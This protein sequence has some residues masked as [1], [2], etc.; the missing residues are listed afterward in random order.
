MSRDDFKPAPPDS[1]PQHALVRRLWEGQLRG[2]VPADI[3]RLM[4]EAATELE[5]NLPATDGLREFNAAQACQG[6]PMTPPTLE[7]ALAKLRRIGNGAKCHI[8][9]KLPTPKEATALLAKIEVA[10]KLVEFLVNLR[11]ASRGIAGYHLNGN[12]AEWDEFEE[13]N[14]LATYR[15]PTPAQPLDVSRLPM[16]DPHPIE[17]VKAGC[18]PVTGQSGSGEVRRF[19]VHVVDYGVDADLVQVGGPSRI[20][21]VADE[22]EFT[23]VL[24]ADFD[25]LAAENARLSHGLQSL[26]ETIGR[27]LERISALLK[28][29]GDKPHLFTVWTH[30]NSMH[31]Q[32]RAALAPTTKEGQV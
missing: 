24:A 17:L 2:D 31:N 22:A 21:G 5:A 10:D 12:I 16:G 18:D 9:E 28:T 3:K 8:D 13:M 30:L 23:V 4:A 29:P 26:Y 14:L 6:D 1:T 25:Q 32:A 19:V 27:E 15:N 20:Q 7:S 11:A